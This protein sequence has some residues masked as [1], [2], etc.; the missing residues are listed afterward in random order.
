[1]EGIPLELRHEVQQYPPALGEELMQSGPRMRG[2]L[3]EEGL[4][5]WCSQG[6]AIA[7][8]AARSW[9]AA[10]EYY[11]VSPLVLPALGVGYFFLWARE[12]EMVSLDGPSIGVAFFK[13]STS[14]VGRIQGHQ[15]ESW[16]RTGHR[17]FKGTW[18]SAVLETRFFE[19]SPELLRHLTMP[20]LER[21]VGLVD[22]LGH[23]SNELALECL[24]LSQE[25]F[26]QIGDSKESLISLLGVL[27]EK[28]WREVRACLEAVPQALARVEGI[29]RPEFLH[30]AE[31]LADSGHPGICSFVIEG[32]RTL[33]QIEREQQSL[34][35]QGASAVM[36]VDA[37]MVPEVFK[38]A[39]LVLS[40]ISPGRFPLWLG[41]GLRIAREN[42]DG[43]L[44]YFR[45]ES[46]CSEAVLES[47]SH[48]VE[49][50]RFRDI[51]SLY[52]RALAGRRVDIAPTEELTSKGLGWVSKERATTEGSTVYLP[53]V[54]DRFSDKGSNFGW[55]KVVATHQVAHLEF[56]TF[57]FAFQR[58]SIYFKDLRTSLWN[59]KHSR[60]P[61][62]RGPVE[63]EE[64]EALVP[65]LK[66]FFDLFPERKLALDIFTVVED[67][68]VDSHV[69]SEYMGI[70]GPYSRVQE[71]ALRERP[72]IEGLGP[73]EALLEHLVR[74]SLQWQDGH[75]V[76]KKQARLVTRIDRIMKMVLAPRATVEDAAEATIRIYA[77]LSQ[78]AGQ[79]VDQEE[80]P[81]QEGPEG[82][83]GQE[84]TEELLQ[85]SQYSGGESSA[86]QGSADNDPKAKQK[87]YASPK[88]VEYRGDLKP[89]LTQLLARLKEASPELKEKA[90]ARQATREGIQA[91]LAQSVEIDI[92]PGDAISTRAF[93]ENVMRESGM[94][95]RDSDYVRGPFL[96]TDDEG[97]PLQSAEP[98]TYVYSEWDFRAN[99]Y[100]PRW[101]IVREKRVPEGDDGF[102]RKTIENY[103]SLLNQIR[104]HFELAVPEAFRK[105]RRVKDGEDLELDA[106][107]EA[108]VDIRAGISPSEKLYWKRN[109][110]E[111]DV[112]VAFLLD[113]SA[114]TAEAIEE[115]RHPYP[116]WD[117][118]DDPMD[119][120][121]WLRNRRGEAGRRHYKRIIDLEKE[122]AV[123][124]TQ[125]LATLGDKYGIYGFSGYGRENVEFYT[126]KGLEEPFDDR[127]KRRIDKIAPLHATRMGPAIRHAAQKLLQVEAKTRVLFLISDGRPQD[128]GYSREGVEKE[129]AV[130]DTK[131]ALNEAQRKNIVPFCLTVDKTGHD[132]LKTMCQDMGYEVLADIHSL[133]QR[134][135]YLYRRLTM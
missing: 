100:K 34:V 69:V 52:C 78:L 129:Y 99:D 115:A 101:C 132:Y 95:P 76:P 6:L 94:P 1:M 49:L 84:D 89:E 18:K 125:A 105:I 102:Y 47:L 12:G 63:A 32:S 24:S 116:G 23:R 66:R 110:V 60:D 39:P 135:P 109:K 121:M 51:L 83:D 37:M 17:L 55:L 87:A 42:R 118:P 73:R 43:G 56:S 31:R 2:L 82:G 29:H 9:E 28:S 71:A 7:R 114:S 21:L 93:A 33:G 74:L 106:V 53:P 35:F 44:A 25:V 46:A 77:M 81:G 50:S 91:L 70:R 130:H 48:A 45:L 85:Q 15:V 92:P 64:I 54:V 134:L 123:L 107:L 67:G 126:I 13:S 59:E 133:P 97:G 27:V 38:N 10:A 131:M 117:A 8:Q 40:R 127:I 112:A 111:R 3:D 98:D 90:A 11:K 68:R 86:G 16:A 26:S 122:S 41:E 5:R 20:E 120:M 75:P 79:E 58:P 36:A 57:A 4:V 119:Y 14:V 103:T 113:M 104:R 72:P 61:L 65:D 22:R 19:L 96:H 128:R 108:L 62:L 30:L 124:L 80:A 88:P